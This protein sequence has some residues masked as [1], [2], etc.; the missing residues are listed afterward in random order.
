[1]RR[2]FAL[3]LVALLSVA[4]VPPASSL[5]PAP[6]VP[7][8]H[9]ELQAVA[10]VNVDRD[11]D[12]VITA[13]GTVNITVPPWATVTENIFFNVTINNTYWFA[14][15]DPP[16]AT[17]TGSGE[18]SFTVNVTVPGR[19]SIDAGAEIWV[20][21]NVSVSPGIGKSWTASTGIPIVQY[22]GVAITPSTS[23]SP[24]NF[25]AQAGA[26]SGFQFRLQNL[27]NG[28]DSF[29]IHV[30]NIAELQ[31][32]GMSVYLPTPVSVPAK[33]TANVN[34]NISIPAS[35]V[36]ANFSMTISALSTGAAAKG[37]TIVTSGEKHL[38]VTPHDDTGG[39]GDGGGT[40]TT[41]PKGFLP[42]PGAWGAVVAGA[43]AALIARRRLTRP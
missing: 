33:V 23:T 34:G 41:K 16:S 15:I 40:N 26:D 30:D 24:A 6:V 35:A 21:A 2:A 19:V 7:A 13:N 9:V 20:D 25:S 36:P 38:R 8:V 42:G 37:Q 22:Y 10:P 32:S 3:G 28:R 5:P 1:M 29:E 43:A 31:A 18:V 12:A 4:A 27:G 14:R 11:D 17:L 39:G